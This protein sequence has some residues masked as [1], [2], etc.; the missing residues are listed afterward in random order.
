MCPNA[1][2]ESVQGYIADAAD[3]LSLS[4]SYREII[5]SPERC[6][7][8]NIPARVGGKTKVLTAYRVQH[9]SVRGPYKGGIR[10]HPDVEL[11]EVSGLASLMTWKCSLL[12]LPYGG[13]KGGIACDP[14]EMSEDELEALTRK[15]VR[16]MMPNIG[17]NVDIPAPDVNTDERIM[18]WIMDETSSLCGHNLTAAVT[19]K[20][21]CLGGSLGRRESTGYGV[22]RV[23]LTTLG[24]L[25]RNP[26]ECTAAIQGFGKVG[27]WAARELDRTG[28]RV[29]AVG[30]V[31]GGKFRP[32]GLDVEGLLNYTSSSPGHLLA[33]YWGEG[34]RDI[35]NLELL[36]LDVDLLVPAALEN[37]I[38]AGI[39]PG[40]RA[41]LIVEGAN[42]PITPGADALLA[43]RGAV[44]VPDILANGGGVIV[45]YLEWVQNM[46][47]IQ[48]SLGEVTDKLDSIL[49]DRLREVWL[50]AQERGTS[51]RKAAYCLAIGRVMEALQMRNSR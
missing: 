48:W 40:I 3:E 1:L 22:A 5:S 14:T 2:M 6:L 18:A 4:D 31:T 32:G 16:M 29:V 33:G 39:A 20:P 36:E 15:Y 47:C 45:S 17:P 41:T 9:S 35:G 46:Q 7:I 11:E 51:L 38:D 13:A 34:V 21:L 26:S 44:V 42:G 23:A 10:F 30:D 27:T 50:A 19:G 49:S 25:G 12:G 8:I 37:A 28:T 24:F 43:Q